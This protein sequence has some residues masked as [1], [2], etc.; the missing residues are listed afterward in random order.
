MICIV[1]KFSVP[2]SLITLPLAGRAPSRTG[3]FATRTKNSDLLSSLHYISLQPRKHNWYY[4][5]LSNES[6]Y[7]PA[8]V[9]LYKGL[10]VLLLV[11]VLVRIFK[12][13]SVSTVAAR[14][15][16]SLVLVRN[17]KFSA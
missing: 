5:V 1:L 8:L 10:G 6:C 9:C 13:L 15:C 16:D 4:V 14:F 3:M 17:S 7:L 11:L 2:F 12:I